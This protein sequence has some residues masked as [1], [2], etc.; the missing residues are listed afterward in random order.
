MRV[1]YFYVF[2]DAQI[3]MILVYKKGAK[4]RRLNRRRRRSSF[5]KLN[6]EW[7]PMKK[8]LFER[9]VE[10]MQQHNEI[11]RGSRAPSAQLA[12]MLSLSGPFVS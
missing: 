3:R 10:S 1:I 2:A 9:L 12:L 6:E 11:V 4:G 8:Q 7:Q 5:R